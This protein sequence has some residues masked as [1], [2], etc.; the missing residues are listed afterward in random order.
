MEHKD[1]VREKLA[2]FLGI[3][4]LPEDK[5]TLERLI[6][7][8]NE[9]YK[10]TLADDIHCPLLKSKELILKKK[11]EVK[12]N[13]DFIM[14]GKEVPAFLKKHHFGPQRIYEDDKISVEEYVPSKTCSRQDFK[15]VEIFFGAI[16]QLSTYCQLFA[17]HAEEFGFKK[18]NR[19]LISHI[20]DKGIYS[21][22]EENLLKLL[23]SDKCSTDKETLE[24]LIKWLRESSITD[25][26]NNLVDEGNRL[27]MVICHNDFFWLNVLKKNAGGMMLI[28]YEY[29]AYNP[30]GWDI[31]NYYTERNFEYI[32]ADHSFK[33]YKE[34]PGL[35]ER[36]M[37]YRYYLL[38]M[39]PAFDQSTPVDAQLL[40]DLASCR[41]DHL[42]DIDLLDE[43]CDHI[44]FTR[45]VC[46]IN[47]QWIFFN[48]LMIDENPTWPLAEYTFGRI[49]L[50]EDLMA[51]LNFH[52]ANT[53]SFSRRTSTAISTGYS[54]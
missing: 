49:K 32:E 54:P 35:D 38:C 3:P 20:L 26:I 34:L 23:K 14:Y 41:Y 13:A 37:V 42:I 45:M 51:T 50:Q 36:S 1:T 24:Q 21:K 11:E 25:D 52:K 8:S 22:A 12:P 16:Q 40:F 2:E 27:K 17:D 29:T 19:L 7:F 15:K 5:V 48:F 53:P 47:L 6:G 9:V 30:I 46:L 43:L 4:H 39:N 10:V 28:D 18:D 44:N 31:A 33:Y